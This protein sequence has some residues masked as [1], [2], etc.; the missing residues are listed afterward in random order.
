MLTFRALQ[1]AAVRTGPA[2]Q[3]RTDQRLPAG[4]PASNAERAM[5]VNRR[6]LTRGG[7][8]TIGRT[9]AA[10]SFLEAIEGNM[11]RTESGF[12]G[13]ER[14]RWKGPSPGGLLQSIM[15]A[16]L[17]A[18][19]AA[20]AQAT[21]QPGG[22]IGVR[23]WDFQ[24]PVTSI[25]QQMYDLHAYIFWV[26]VIIFIGVFGVMFYS[27]LKHRKSV[28]HEAVQ[29]H[30]NTFV[31][32]IWTVIPFLI[33]LFMAYPATKTILAMKDTSAPGL[34][35]KVTGYQ[36][37]W[38]Y[39]YLQDGFGFYSNLTTPLAQIENREPKGPHYLL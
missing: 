27:I 3:R 38:N 30:E 11:V 5:D 18:P 1:R 37:K 2:R 20:F 14:L 29:F 16:A 24:P 32:I 19:G 39:D 22:A 21:H 8:R 7:N 13:G 17:L 26:C 23:S 28:G 35:I 33:L 9:S 36:W 31:E 15:A 4:N 25:A 34:T 6:G 12:G 10:R